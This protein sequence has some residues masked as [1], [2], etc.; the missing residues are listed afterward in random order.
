[1]NEPGIDEKNKSR[2]WRVLYASVG[3]AISL[4]REIDGGSILV[5]KVD[6]A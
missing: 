4:A 6:A 1:M 3:E 5:T 2:D